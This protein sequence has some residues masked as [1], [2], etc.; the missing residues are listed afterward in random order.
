VITQIN[1]KRIYSVDDLFAVRSKSR[2]G[3]L[4]DMTIIR[5]GYPLQVVLKYGY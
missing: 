3:D 5:N 1:D 2:K 4:W